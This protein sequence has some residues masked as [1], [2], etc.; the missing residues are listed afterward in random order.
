MEH[1]GRSDVLSKETDMKNFDIVRHS[2][3]WKTI[4]TN[5][6][7]LPFRQAIHLPIVFFG[8]CELLL[9]K[10]SIEIQQPEENLKFGM[11]RIGNLWS[12]LHGWNTQ[13]KKTRLEVRGKLVFKGASFIGN[14]SLI[15]VD[16]NAK[17]TLGHRS[18]FTADVKIAC[19]K[20]I[21]IDDF[22][23][24]AWESQI[25]DTN[26]HYIADEQGVVRG[27]C[28]GIHIGKYC[29]IGN[30]VSV[31]RGSK[32]SDWTTI[33]S[34]SLVSKDISDVENG[35]FAGTPVKLLKTGQ[36]RVFNWQSE[37]RLN[38]FFA[39]YPDGEITLK[40]EEIEY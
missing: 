9:N 15:Y 8:N 20:E 5:F 24:I 21:Y 4:V 1:V 3:W 28:K 12:N 7:V 11:I 23:R 37:L 22:T 14:G 30:R 18:F 39:E 2:N 13:T 19:Y 34:N 29:W 36:K 32:L 6:K 38:D 33:G 27:K 31:M 10:N 25:F 26:F 35:T 17:L 40:Q 16:N